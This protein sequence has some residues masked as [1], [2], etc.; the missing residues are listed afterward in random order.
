ML[1]A[2]E[3]GSATAQGSILLTEGLRSPGATLCLHGLVCGLYVHVLGI[4]SL[5]DSSVEMVLCNAFIPGWT[6]VQLAWHF[7]TV[8]LGFLIALIPED[9]ALAFCTWI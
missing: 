5:G 9:C 8:S 6:S 7:C 2:L 3:L 1:G 4:S